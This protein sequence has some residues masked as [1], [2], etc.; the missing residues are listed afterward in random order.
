[1][2]R[3]GKAAIIE[4]LKEKFGS[5][6]YFYLAD[7]STLTAEEITKVR[8]IFYSKGL[9]LKV[10][11]NTLIKKALD[12]ISES[13]YTDIYSQLHGPTTIIFTET[14]NLPAKAIQDLQNNEKMEG[15]VFK[16]AYIDSAVFVGEENLETLTK[17]K[18]KFEL[19]GE[20]IGILQ[21]PAKNVISAL[22]SGG[23][24]LAGIVKTLSEK[25]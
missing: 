3:E 4:E 24:K 23:D 19:L 15:F 12:Q 22:K 20:V 13:K 11:K 25:E 14:S 17:L 16:A 1:M 5:S 6:E 7:S 21:S 9:Q 2:R 10:A 8:R 18:S